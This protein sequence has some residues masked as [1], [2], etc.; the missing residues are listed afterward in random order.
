MA[1]VLV[2]GS[3]GAIG[4]A[5]CRELL[6]RGHHVRGFDRVPTPGLEDTWVADIAVSDGWSRAMAGIDAVVH[7]AAEPNDADFSVLVGP[8]VVGL[9]QVMNA[10]RE[11]KVPRVV[12]ASSMQVLGR[13]APGSGPARVD[14]A[15]PSNHYALTKLWAEQMGAMY[16]RRFGMSIIAARIA[17]MV[18]NVREAEH[19]VEIGRP[20]WYLSANDAGRFFAQAIEAPGMRFAILYACSLGGERLFD[21]KPARRLIGYEARDRW[22]EGLGFDFSPATP[23]QADGPGKS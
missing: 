15:C 11:A 13:R 21:M 1:R 23:G 4:Q 3:A 6:S 9:Y 16:A 7:L 19:M 17:W 22:P 12:L 8:N 14:E 20:D 10:A 18:R 5:V 2:T